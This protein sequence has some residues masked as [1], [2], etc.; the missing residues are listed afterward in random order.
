[1]M[2]PLETYLSEL[3]VIR[4]SG[5]AVKETS[6][7]PVLVGLLNEVGKMLKPKVVCIFNPKNQGA[8][9]PDGGLYEASQF[10]RGKGALVEGTL[11]ARGCV[12]VKGTSEDVAK[13]AQSKQVQ[14]YLNK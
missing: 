1:M 9:I 6:Y 4:S 14:G 10:Q 7:Y 12:E 5:A 2:Q 3:R 8:G 13:V 11:P